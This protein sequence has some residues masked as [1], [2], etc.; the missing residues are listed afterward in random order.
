[1]L[2]FVEVGELKL[3]K[4]LA[5]FLSVE[6]KSVCRRGMMWWLLVVGQWGCTSQTPGLHLVCAEPLRYENN[7]RPLALFKPMT[8]PLYCNAVMNNALQQFT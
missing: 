7:Y 2:S 3:K 8:M 5:K 1:M 4:K 6:I